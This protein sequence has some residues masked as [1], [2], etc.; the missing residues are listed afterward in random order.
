MKRSSALFAAP[1]AALTAIATLVIPVAVALLLWASSGANINLVDSAMRAG[2]IAW[3]LALGAPAHLTI[4][5]DDAARLG[6]DG[7]LSFAIELAPL[8]IT[9]LIARR[10][11]R[12]GRGL[13]GRDG[14]MGGVAA[15]AVVFGLVAVLASTLTATDSVSTAPWAAA[16]GA[17]LISGLA[18]ITGAKPWRGVD[19]QTR[20]ESV[21]EAL[22]VASGIAAAVLAAGAAALAIAMVF[23]AG[24][25]ISAFEML[26][27]DAG[28]ALGLALAQILLLP[29]A[30]VWAIAWM[31]GPGVQ[32]GAGSVSTPFG[33]TAAPVPLIPLL[34][35]VPEGGSPWLG[36]VCALPVLAG[37]L[38]ALAP[39]MGSAVEL[40]PLRRTL[41]SLA[42]SLTVA[43]TIGALAWLAGGGIG[44]GRAGWFGPNALSVLGAAAL[45]LSLGAVIGA[46]IPR[47]FVL[48]EADDAERPAPAPRKA[49]TSSASRGRGVT[50]ASR[51]PI[52]APEP[53]D[54]DE[55]ERDGND[56]DPSDASVSVSVSE[57]SDVEWDEPSSRANR[58]FSVDRADAPR[59]ASRARLAPADEDAPEPDI[60]ADID[61]DTDGAERD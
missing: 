20:N 49:V 46:L 3:V 1:R 55:H 16:L 23:G 26:H 31:L 14:R 60:Y 47:G 11:W 43:V 22:R 25:M 10:C 7:Q 51:L 52:D 13:S 21:A 39:R 18:T 9:A 61:P 32:L 24:R 59:G 57:D 15:V 6:F 53:V 2:V 27:A 40:P 44:P 30:I 48:G 29:N 58:S 28:S 8:G 34:G 45:L 19:G 54:V 33:T 38:G 12:I 42:G 5:A 4:S 41:V 37:L 36:A 35:A 56:A 17:V 50:R